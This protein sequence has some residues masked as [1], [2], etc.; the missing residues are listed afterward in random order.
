MNVVLVKQSLVIYIIYLYFIDFILFIGVKVNIFYFVVYLELNYLKIIL[1]VFF[2]IFYIYLYFIFIIYVYYIFY[3]IIINIKVFGINI[4]K[5][6][7][8]IMS[9]VLIE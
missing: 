9:F 6:Y 7:K 2:F 1:W 4:I 8:S 3:N 5:L